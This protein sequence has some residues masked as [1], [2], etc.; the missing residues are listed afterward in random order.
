MSIG[1]KYLDFV[2]NTRD[3]SGTDEHLYI[4]LSDIIDYASFDTTY[5]PIIHN[6]QNSTYG[7][8]T[9]TKYGHNK[10][11]DNLTTSSSVNGESLSAHQGYV[12]NEMINNLTIGDLANFDASDIDYDN[13]I[14]QQIW[15]QNPPDDVNTAIDKLLRLIFENTVTNIVL[16]DPNS[17]A[18]GAI[19]INY[20]SLM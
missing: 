4:K 15:G 9:A 2:I 13:S 20:E 1:Q 18:T 12:L 7:M 6:S 10:V 5:A 16:V 11:I 17:D 8:G 3:N 19:R 14:Y